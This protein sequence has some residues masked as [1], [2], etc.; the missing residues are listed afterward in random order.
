MNINKLIP[1]VSMFI[2]GCS[3]TSIEDK[4][5]VSTS[6][7]PAITSTPNVEISTKPSPIENKIEELKP[8]E[9]F[10]GKIAFLGYLDSSGK[11]SDNDPYKE[12]KLYTEIYTVEGKNPI[13]KKLTNLKSPIGDILWSHN[14][15]K[16]AFIKEGNIFT[17]DY[18]SQ[19]IKQLT[20][21]EKNTSIREFVW[22]P[23]DK[24]IAFTFVIDPINGKNNI[25]KIEKYQIKLINI[26]NNIIEELKNNFDIKE[27]INNL[28][29]SSFD[30]SLYFRVLL[31][32]YK[33]NFI[34]KETNLLMKN[35]SGIF[36][37]DKNLI[38]S[39]KNVTSNEELK[40]YDLS[41]STI[42][43]LINTKKLLKGNTDESPKILLPSASSYIFRANFSPDNKKILFTGQ[44]YNFATGPSNLYY[45]YIFD[46]EKNILITLIKEPLEK[47]SSLQYSAS[48]QNW[49]PDSKQ[50][51]IDIEYSFFDYKK[52]LK[53]ISKIFNIESE[54]P[55]K[56]FD[57]ILGENCN[58]YSNIIWSDK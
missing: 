26:E 14:G 23:D 31:D 33:Y 25:S 3:L 8:I 17:I 13:P 24:Y 5:K 49:S 42:K 46:I 53:P 37:K 21:N 12:K 27:S 38:F 1:L 56:T 57:S 40:L 9:K 30:N 6:S 18:Y 50:I 35:I 44:T 2:L 55:I 39:E 48:S 16:I 58:C 52:E 34:K 15:T 43:T 51:I 19:E 10:E 7:K 54:K 20:N 29:W 11:L 28:N 45:P 41:N 36:V 4:S 32:V 22:S 47:I